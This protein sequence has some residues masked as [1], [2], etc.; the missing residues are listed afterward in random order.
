M[1]MTELKL[2]KRIFWSI[3]IS[4]IIYTCAFTREIFC[5]EMLQVDITTTDG[6]NLLVKDSGVV[7]TA[8]PIIFD[9][10][11]KEDEVCFY[12]LSADKGKTFGGYVPMEDGKVTLYPNEAIFPDNCFY[13]K[14]KKIS[15]E[16]G[17]ANSIADAGA[18]VDDINEA[19]NDTAG[20]EDYLKADSDK[21]TGQENA[22]NSVNH[23]EDYADR[24]EIES[25]VYKVFFDMTV[26]DIVINNSEVLE[27]WKRENQIL[28]VNVSDKKGFLSRIIATV[29][30]DV[31]Y[32]AHYNE[33]D[34]I[35]ET[36]CEIN[37]NQQ[38]KDSNGQCLIIKA[39]DCARN[40]MTSSYNFYI[41]KE[42]P[43]ITVDGIEDGSIVNGEAGLLINITEKI[44]E[45]AF[46][47][48]KMVRR[49]NGMESVDEVCENA[50]DAGGVKKIRID[51]DGEYYFC[52]YAYDYAG[53]YSDIVE[54]KFT[55]D[56]HAPL[57]AI[58]GVTNG[59]DINKPVDLKISVKENLYE[60]CS[61]KVNV[62]RKRQG[63]EV[64][65]PVSDYVLTSND[66]ERVISLKNDGDYE[67]SVVAT[68]KA[69]RTSE[70]KADFRIDSTSP[71]I[72]I[73]GLNEGEATNRKP[74]VKIYAGDIFYDST[75]LNT[76]VFKKDKSGEYK[77]ID[78]STEVLRSEQDV[79]DI[80]IDE[81][82][83][84]KISCRASDRSGNVSNEELT[85]KVDYTPPVIGELDKYDKKYFSR[86]ALSGELDS[87]IS[88]ANNF[89]YSAYINDEE[90]DWNKEI[91][92][93][94]KYVL[95]VTAEDEAGNIAD[96]SASFIID[97]TAPQIVVA[98]IRKDVYIKKGN[99][100]S[101]T[102]SDE[103]DTLKK[104]LVNGKEI[105]IIDDGKR[106]AFA[107]SDYG[108]YM[109]DVEAFDEA[110]NNTG[111]AIKGY[112]RAANVF[113]ENP[114]KINRTSVSDI[115]END[116]N[117]ND[118]KGLLIGFFSV[119]SGT[120]GLVFRGVVTH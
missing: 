97:R 91:I 22:E 119:L 39:Y 44:P 69:G 111:T 17:A 35:S 36:V 37:L 30:N 95:W 90:A 57:V 46:V 42:K 117:E 18:D 1:K 112:C 62:A 78:N 118:M 102:L 87:Y 24:K 45:T 32:E 81:E 38:A 52:A 120:Y 86:L 43:V 98:G 5:A 14:F 79:K 113:F 80:E 103:N 68:D 19:N 20:A 115:G 63:I 77:I 84:Y 27:G 76:L 9:A 67:V 82:G 34:C 71:E 89:K 59:S 110:G 8:V 72:V 33:D 83:D 11:M 29:G 100:V 92:E 23:S 88:D 25:S 54:K 15:P 49:L 107:V 64:I 114:Q 108:E 47:S 65:L 109:I 6:E 116:E 7:Y 13:M 75:V 106:A 48:Y 2:L 28:K 101:I 96:R 21:E 104:V 70:A 58:D 85:F 61:V 73:A 3:I 40:T 99:V 60:G 74:V 31:V 50:G 16:Y 105:S 56:I 66:E 10:R 26:P 41:D 12:S 53:N 51:E 93:E 4:S 94:G 55:V